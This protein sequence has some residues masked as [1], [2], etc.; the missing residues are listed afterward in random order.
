M[1][2]KDQFRIPLVFN[3][4]VSIFKVFFELTSTAIVLF[5]TFIFLWSFYCASSPVQLFYY[6]TC[7]K[8]K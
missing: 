2:R 6:V 4:S 8:R 1:K 5:Y 7:V 3:V